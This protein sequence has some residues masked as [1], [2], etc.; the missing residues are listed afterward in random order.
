M[1]A[2]LIKPNIP[3]KKLISLL[4]EFNLPFKYTGDGSCFIN[5]K[6]PDF[7]NINH[8]KQIIELFGRYWHDPIFGRKKIP[9]HLT[10]IGCRAY[11]QKFGFKTLI[12]WEEELNTPFKVVQK[13]KM[14]ADA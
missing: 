4:K 9:W 6:N 8:K 5:Y 3:E 11:Y 7:I 13:I 12:I 10:E 2:R 14:F 1:R